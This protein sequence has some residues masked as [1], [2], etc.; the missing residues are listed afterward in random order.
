MQPDDESAWVNVYMIALCSATTSCL[1]TVTRSIV[2]AWLLV[3]LVIE[4]MS[5]VHFCLVVLY[6]D[7]RCALFFNIK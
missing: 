7:F 5:S 6:C 1:D 2:S 4:I 3:M